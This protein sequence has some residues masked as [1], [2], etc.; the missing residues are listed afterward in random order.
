MR[1]NVFMLNSLVGL[2]LTCFTTVLQ[3]QV[4]YTID[5]SNSSIWVEGTSTL[6]DWKAEVGNW[7]G[8]ITVDGSGTIQTVDIS[9]EVASLDGGRGPD[10]NDKIYKALK[11]S[12][13]PEMTFSGKGTKATG[14]AS[15]AAEGTFSMAGSTQPMVVSA[16]GS[17]DSKLAGNIPIKLS[18]YQI[19]PPT[20]MFGTIV[21]HDDA[22]IVFD[23]TL[24]KE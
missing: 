16:T 22:T 4:T 18:D 5:T 15:L 19:E 10:M 13:Q 1:T 7:E 24:T 2:F 9:L 17:L 6:R 23:I 14:D 8:Q 21:T 3:A 12:E 20:A 11:S